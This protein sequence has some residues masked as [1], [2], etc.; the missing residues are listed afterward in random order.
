MGTNQR[1][2]RKYRRFTFAISQE[3]LRVLRIK[4]AKNDVSAGELLRR[5]IRAWLGLPEPEGCDEGEYLPR[6]R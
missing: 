4:A 1:K 6:G 2:G 5:M 3:E